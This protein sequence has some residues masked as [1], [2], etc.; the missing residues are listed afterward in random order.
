MKT[1][2]FIQVTFLPLFFINSLFAQVISTVP[3]F[4][5]QTDELTI[6]FHADKGNQGLKDFTG[7]V[8]AHTGVITNLSTSS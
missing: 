2:I 1:K 8:Y 4:P 7:D 6:Y 5:T 3:V